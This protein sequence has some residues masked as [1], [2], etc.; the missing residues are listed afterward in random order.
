VRLTLDGSA[1]ELEGT[2][3]PPPG[4]GTG[5]A[6]AI[7]H[8]TATLTGIVTP[9]GTA[10]YSFEYGTTEA[11]GSRTPAQSASGKD[12][13][14][15]VTAL[16]GGLLPSTTYHYRLVASN[17]RGS[18]QAEDRTFTTAAPGGTAPPQAAAPPPVP[19]PTVRNSWST[20]GGRTRV[21]RLTAVDVPAGGRVDLTCRGRSCPFKR[22]RY[23]PTNGR[24]VLAP[25]FRGRRL[26][27]RTRIDVRITG[28]GIRTKLVRYVTKRRGI[29]R[30]TTITG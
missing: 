6:S 4:V 10:Q 21:V 5:G 24:A 29:P 16:I 23:A 15:N 12:E 22:K 2:E 11:Y 17:E 8:D 9:S 1:G 20:L 7:G 26:R 30:S 27:P 28:P 13:S 14:F 19:Q 3:C 18:S 25:A